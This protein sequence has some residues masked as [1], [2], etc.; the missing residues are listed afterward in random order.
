MISLQITWYGCEAPALHV[1]GLVGD[2]V[3]D[4]DQDEEYRH[5]Q[6]H[7]PGYQLWGNQEP[8]LG[9]MEKREWLNKLA[10]LWGEAQKKI[11]Y[12][13]LKVT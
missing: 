11:A 9:K 7:P 5:Q 3:E 6:C 1:G 12:S 4:V 2:I 8:S 13:Y 10:L